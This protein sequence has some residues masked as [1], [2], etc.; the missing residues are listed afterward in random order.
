MLGGDWTDGTMTDFKWRH[1]QGDVILWSALFYATVSRGFKGGSY[2]NNSTTLTTQYT[3]PIRQEQLT[4]YEIGAKVGI[5]DRRVQINA[6][7]FY[8][9]Y[10]DKQLF[11]TL[12]DPI[13]GRLFQLFNIPKSRVQGFDVDVV[14]TPLTGL[15]VRGAANYTDTK[16]RS[17]FLIP[18]IDTAVNEP[19]V[20]GNRNYDIQGRPFNYAPKWN[21]TADAEYIWEMTSG[22]RPFLGASFLY[23]SATN[24]ALNPGANIA[25]SSLTAIKAFATLD[26]RAGLRGRANVWELMLYGRNVTNTYYWNNAIVYADTAMRYTAMPA[27]YGAQFSYRF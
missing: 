25:T 10:K 26:L 8:Y 6:A 3:N 11:G 16:V 2:L 5:F 24:A 1:F 14:A 12:I 15:T 9:D 7:A 17:S 27:T 20:P 18:N 21:V 13:F 4:A 23:N 19:L 22:L